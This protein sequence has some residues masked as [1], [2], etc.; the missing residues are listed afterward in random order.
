MP[1]RRPNLLLIM[2]DR[3]RGDC[4]SLERHPALLTPVID[5]IGGAGAHFTH[6]YTTCASCIPAR[7]SLLTGQCPATSGVVGFVYG[8]RLT[9]P[10]LPQILA[11]AGYHTAIAGRYMHQSPYGN[12]YGFQT[13]VLGTAYIRDDDYARMLDAQ[14]PDLGGIR[15]IGLS[16]NGWQSRPWPLAEHLHP[17]N[18]VVSQSR[19]ILS[20]HD[21]RRPLFIV[22]SFLAPHPPLFPPGFY[23]ERY[24][25]LGLPQP[26]IGDWT[27]PPLN[28]A[29]GIGVEAHRTCLAGEALRGALAGYFGLINHLDDQLYWLVTEFREKSKAMRR[30]WV[31]IFLSDHGEMLGDHYYWRHCEPYEGAS[32]VPLLMRGSSELGFVPG[33]RCS[34]PVCLEDILPTVLE[35]AGLTVPDAVDGRSLLP[36]LRGEAEGVRHWLHGEHAPF[37]SER[38]GY[39]FLTDGEV[40]YV[41]RPVD[42]SEQLFDLSADPMELRDLS[43]V[44]AWQE[45]LGLWRARIVELLRHRPEGFSDG[46]RLWAGRKYAA[47]LPHASPAEVRTR[48]AQH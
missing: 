14:V 8:Y 27:E 39:H 5:E 33:L 3:M 32:R 24:L 31:V 13:R 7:R 19:R 21:S 18:W 17:T 29:L 20:E 15:G 28:D 34:Q 36:V 44:D 35:L 42:G 37:Y 11:E 16:Y 26:A 22:S 46:K 9:A 25:R 40:K 48:E 47:A 12:P 43:Q 41:W 30:P 1:D 2:P 23:M 10:T 6:A 4:L 45:P 38:Q